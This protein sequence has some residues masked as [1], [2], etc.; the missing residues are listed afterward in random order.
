MTPAFIYDASNVMNYSFAS[1]MESLVSNKYTMP[2]KRTKYAEV[3]AKLVKL[4]SETEDEGY[5][6]DIAIINKWANILG[7]T[8]WFYWTDFEDVPRDYLD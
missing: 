6:Q 5:K 4:V 3:G 7:L 1:Y 2:Y 8:D